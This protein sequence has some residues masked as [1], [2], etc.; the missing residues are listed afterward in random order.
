VSFE[1]KDDRLF[2]CGDFQTGASTVVQSAATGKNVGKAIFQLLTTGNRPPAPKDLQRCDEV[3]NN[4][5]TYLPC[6]HSDRC[7]VIVGYNS[8]P[9][10]LQTNFFGIK[11]QNPFILSA[12]P[13]TYESISVSSS[14]YFVHD[15]ITA[16]ATS[17]RRRP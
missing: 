1:S 4:N 16:T 3:P 12:S 13:L 7:Q 17:R 15:S 11:L 9:V 8:V 10:P 5:Y 6:V 14:L 2:Y